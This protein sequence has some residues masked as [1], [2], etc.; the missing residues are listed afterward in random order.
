VLTNRVFDRLL[1]AK[2]TRREEAHAV[3]ASLRDFRLTFRLKKK[4]ATS[5]DLTE[6]D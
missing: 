5:D 6:N 3:A 4:Y 2:V 1:N